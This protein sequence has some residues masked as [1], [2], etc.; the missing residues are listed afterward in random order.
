M[1]SY[2]IEVHRVMSLKACLP[3]E[4]KLNE[5]ILFDNDNVNLS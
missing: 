5:H 3:N 2:Q 4:L 1:T